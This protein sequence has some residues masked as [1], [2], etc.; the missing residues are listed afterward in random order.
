MLIMLDGFDVLVMAFTAAPISAEWKLSGA[1][2]GV[3]FSAGLFGMAAG[4]LFLAPWADRF[5]RQPIILV[6]LVVIALGMFAS[7]S[8]QA[9]SAAAANVA[10]TAT[11]SA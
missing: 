4:S 9:D 1:E 5:G 6:C 8:E 10:A 2:L 3:L 7:G 11:V